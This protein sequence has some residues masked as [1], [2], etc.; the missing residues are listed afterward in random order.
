MKPLVF[1]GFVHSHEIKMISPL[2]FPSNLYVALI[3]A[4]PSP[5]PG[6]QAGGHH[7]Y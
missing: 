4:G 5:R 3:L 7:G 1:D 6:L 2:L